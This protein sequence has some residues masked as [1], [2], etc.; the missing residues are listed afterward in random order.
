MFSSL[1]G[2]RKKCFILSVLPECADNYRPKVEQMKYAKDLTELREKNATVCN[3]IS[4]SM[5]E[6]KVN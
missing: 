5:T 3:E 6:E 1:H 4:V 2:T